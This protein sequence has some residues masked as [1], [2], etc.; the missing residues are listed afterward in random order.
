MS[1]VKIDE[2]IVHPSQV[3]R[4]QFHIDIAIEVAKGKLADLEVWMGTFERLSVSEA[5]A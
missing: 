2:L 1:Y 5:V 4:F 3:D